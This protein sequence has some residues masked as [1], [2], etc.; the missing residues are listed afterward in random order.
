MSY[1]T[2]AFSKYLQSTFID[3]K[4]GLELTS[5]LN[6]PC[7]NPDRFS[8]LL[9]SELSRVL[10]SSND[11]MTFM[12]IMQ[13][14][15]NVEM[16]RLTQ[17]LTANFYRVLPKQF[18]LEFNRAMNQTCAPVPLNIYY[19]TAPGGGF[20]FL[21]AASYGGAFL[22]KISDLSAFL[23]GNVTA[24]SGAGLTTGSADWTMWILAAEAPT[25]WT[26]QG[27]PLEFF[28]GRTGLTAPSCYTTGS[29]GFGFGLP[30]PSK[31][32][33]Y[34]LTTTDTGQT[35]GEQTLDYANAG[36]EAAFLVKVIELCGANA[37]LG[38]AVD[39]SRVEIRIKNTY[40][41]PTNNQSLSV[42]ADLQSDAFIPYAC[43]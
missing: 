36:F 15:N 29:F 32:I 19:A 43:P 16:P 12:A 3:R 22:I 25:D 20:V 13:D 28:E 14:Y 18:H 31:W 26:W 5:R 21:D 41:E 33:Q 27:D 40:L 35:D 7:D 8:N 11:A 38:F 23:Q 24:E 37:T 2:P 10:N 30:S 6:S 17:E 39:A 34:S 9:F 42:N 1:I 4:A